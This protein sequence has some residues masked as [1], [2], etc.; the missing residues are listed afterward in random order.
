MYL[1]IFPPSQS[2]LGHDGLYRVRNWI[3]GAW[4]VLPNLTAALAFVNPHSAYMAQGG[5]CSLPLRP[6]WYRLALFWGPRYLI[7]IYVVYVAVRIYRHV[8]SEFR[9]FGHGGAS[10]SSMGASGES[11]VDRAMKA[12]K[13]RRHYT[14]PS[15]PLSNPQNENLPGDAEHAPVDVI[16]VY[17]KTRI[18]APEPSHPLP[19][20]GVRRQSTPNWSTSLNEFSFQPGIVPAMSSST[21]TSRRGSQQIAA[22]VFSEDFAPPLYFDRHRESIATL[23]SKRSSTASQ[24]LP[25]IVEV[26]AVPPRSSFQSHTSTNRTV[27]LRRR[28]IQRQL[29]LLFI[30]PCIYMILWVIPFVANVMNYSDYW[31]QNPVFVLRMLQLLCVTIM[32]FM[33]VVIF[34][35]RERPWRHI[36]GS[37]GTVLG[38]FMWWRFC[39]DSTWTQS[40]KTSTAPSCIQGHRGLGDEKSQSQTGILG[41]L[42]RWS[43]SL[44]GSS[45]RGSEVSTATPRPTRTVVTHKRTH[46]GGSD[47]KHLEAER[48]H[49]RL[50]LERAEYDLNRRSLQERRV[51]I[52]SQPVQTTPGRKEW[53]VFP[54]ASHISELSANYTNTTRFDQQTGDDLLTD[55][56][57]QQDEKPYNA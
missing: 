50:A 11:S 28:A 37:D 19:S 7:W 52:I 21:P 1:Q 41:T 47:R 35:W 29:R 53:Y 46:S 51:S 40:R 26:E 20:A 23:G 8:G 54:W 43:V 22:G 33:E 55:K 32:T 48:A 17:K 57:Q 36:P 45:P 24:S 18:S 56:E 44:K 38:S 12:E 15:R 14:R 30:Y 3:F 5:F 9:V 4:V 6:F 2:M 10:S 27:Q 49:E 42:R 31:A 16:G 39:F 34:S 25:P 13:D